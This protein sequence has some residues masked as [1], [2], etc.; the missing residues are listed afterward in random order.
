LSTTPSLWVWSATITSVL[1]L[2]GIDFVVAAKRPHAVGLV[3]AAEW[4]GFHVGAAL[5]CRVTAVPLG[6]RPRRLRQWL[7]TAAAG[8][9]ILSVNACGSPAGTPLPTVAPA[10]PAP[11]ATPPPADSMPQ[12][13]VVAVFENAITHYCRTAA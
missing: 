6:T 7:A 9:V 5:L 11:A 3:E 12:H 4:S 10:R 8:V 1:V 13:I 2:L